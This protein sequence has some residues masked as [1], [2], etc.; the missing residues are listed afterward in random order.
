MSPY[1]PQLLTGVIHRLSTSKMPAFIETLVLIFCHFVQSNCDVVV[2]FLDS[3]TVA[4]ENGSSKSGL[5]LFLAS[6]CDIFTD[7]QGVYQVKLSTMAMMTI[8]STA[9]PRLNAILVK[10][11]LIIQPNAKKIVT[12]SMARSSMFFHC[13]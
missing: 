12:R 4:G 8:L 10:G 3:I 9:D 5:E 11:D 1:I 6:W 13:L 2:S 7:L